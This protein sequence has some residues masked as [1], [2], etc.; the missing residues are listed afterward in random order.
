MDQLASRIAA[1]W[2]H[3]VV[4]EHSWGTGIVEIVPLIR[5]LSANTPVILI[6]YSLG[7][8]DVPMIANGVP[9]REIALAVC[10]DP[11]QAGV[12]QQPG[13]NIKRLLLYHNVSA[14]PIGHAVFT[15]PMVERT[16]LHTTHLAVDYLDALHEKTMAAIADVIGV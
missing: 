15:G 12:V 14:E 8:N 7:A 4:T 2:P 9:T 16:E 13:P 3:A 1:K 6:G 11:S 10:Y 5:K